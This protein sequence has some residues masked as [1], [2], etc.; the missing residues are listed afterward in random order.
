MWSGYSTAVTIT[1]SGLY[2]RINDKNKL[3]TGKTVFD[4]FE[5]FR[6]RY[7]N[8]RSEE[9]MRNISDYFKVPER[10][11]SAERGLCRSV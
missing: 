4:K 3:I 2:L 8:M 7:G 1:E 5:E 9:C 11:L 10:D 6:R